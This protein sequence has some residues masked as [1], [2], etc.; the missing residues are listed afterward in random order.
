MSK[1]TDGG[2]T[3]VQ[4]DM[5]QILIRYKISH[6]SLATG[7][8]KNCQF[9]NIERCTAD[10]VVSESNPKLKM[11]PCVCCWTAAKLDKT[12]AFLQ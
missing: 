6:F 11:P 12:L 1:I 5:I 9:G 8:K 3:I 10:S 4:T 7:A 2:V